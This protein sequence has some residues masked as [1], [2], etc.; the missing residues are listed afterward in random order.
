MADN[1]LQPIENVK[2]GEIV[3]KVGGR[4][5]F[6]TDGYCRYAKRYTIDPC[7]GG[8]RQYLKKG[9]LVDTFGSD[10]ADR[11]EE[12]KQIVREEKGSGLTY[13]YKVLFGQDIVLAERNGTPVKKFI[14][15]SREEGLK[16]ANQLNR[17]N[18]NAQH[19]H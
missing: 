9:T 18:G 6:Q 15:E 16:F 17:A 1:R 3:C 4:K 8:N 10:Y 2:K 7:D 5:N 11:E 13:R 12:R 19:T 14:V